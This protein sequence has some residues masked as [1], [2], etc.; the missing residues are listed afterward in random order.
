MRNP[1]RLVCLI[2][3][4]GLAAPSPARALDVTFTGIVLDTC[5]IAL[6]TPGVMMLSSNGTILGTDQTLGVP[7]TVTVVSI[8]SN[9]IS[10]DEPE[11]LTHPGDYVPSNESIEMNYTGLADH[12]L[13]SSLGLNFNLGLVSLT[14]LFV[15]LRITDPDGF[16]QGT[17]TA[18]TVL[19]CS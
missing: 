1:I 16:V 14:N 17:Y 18:R 2:G 4:A 5:T 13:F 12:P 10:L 19:T 15:N 3:L 9:T 7:A 8:G 6:A 11:L